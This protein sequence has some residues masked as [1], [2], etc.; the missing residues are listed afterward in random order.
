MKRIEPNEDGST[1]AA[2]LKHKKPGEGYRVTG[3]LAGGFQCSKTAA[4]VIDGTRK[5]C[6]SHAHAEAFEIL[7]TTDII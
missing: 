4:W 7:R 3:R 5:V 6:H 1:C 2:M